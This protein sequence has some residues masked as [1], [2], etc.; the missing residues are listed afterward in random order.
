M[1]KVNLLDMQG[2]LVCSRPS[3]RRTKQQGTKQD[4]STTICTTKDTFV[5]CQR[6]P[7]STEL[8]LLVLSS[9]DR[10]NSGTYMDMP[11]LSIT[12]GNTTDIF[13]S[14]I[15]NGV[16]LLRLSG[17]S[18]R[19]AELP[20]GNLLSVLAY[21]GDRLHKSQCNKD[22][23]I[24]ADASAHCDPV[25]K[26]Y[27]ARA[28]HRH[29]NAAAT[30]GCINPSIHTQDDLHSG[31]YVAD[32]HDPS[33][34]SPCTKDLDNFDRDAWKRFK[35]LISEVTDPIVSHDE[36]SAPQRDPAVLSIAQ[37]AYSLI[38]SD[39]HGAIATLNPHSSP[40]GEGLADTKRTQQCIDDQSVSILTTV[41][42]QPRLDR[43]KNMCSIL[44]H[45]VD[46]RDTH[47]LISQT[48]WQMEAI[49]LK[50]RYL[51][52]LAI[53]RLSHINASN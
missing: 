17:N 23:C 2:F 16:D 43:N 11:M 34:A 36:M 12:Q 13:S 40:D 4:N 25:G 29:C 38:Y 26:N 27:L 24:V 49:R 6:Y 20:E 19:R 9:H 53:G 15:H 22:S 39:T 3:R 7:H 28:K 44:A 46:R 21:S 37:P 52:T 48:G 50:E 5:H 1:Q 31:L 8:G 41:E 45:D 51:Q 35:A 47:S 30:S 14:S 42:L 32:K 33:S 18:S 10:F